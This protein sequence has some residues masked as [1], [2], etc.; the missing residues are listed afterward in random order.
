MVKNL[1][2]E[3]VPSAGTLKGCILC[4]ILSF[5]FSHTYN[6]SLGGVGEKK[7]PLRELIVL[8]HATDGK[9]EALA[10]AQIII[11]KN[12]K[13]PSQTVTTIKEEMRHFLEAK[14]TSKKGPENDSQTSDKPPNSQQYETKKV[15]PNGYLPDI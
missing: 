5:M 7:V 11:Y 12:V 9:E 10:L 14:E 15:P 8:Y 3:S 1:K 4:G 13:I 2:I 6:K